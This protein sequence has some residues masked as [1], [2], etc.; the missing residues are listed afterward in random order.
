MKIVNLSSYAFLKLD[1]LPAWKETLLTLCHAHHVKGTI[2]LA[3]EGINLALAGEASDIQAFEAAFKAMPEFAH[4]EFKV[5]YSQTIPFR[6]MLVK[7]KQAVIPMRDADTH[8]GE[9]RAPAMLP[10][11][12]KAR[13][14]AG[15]DIVLLD[16]RNT[17]EIEF[18]KF[19]HAVELDL[20]H[21]DDFNKAVEALKATHQDKTIVSY[22][23]GGVRCEK[24]A[25]SML[26]AGFKDVYQ[27][28]G[29]ILKYFELCGGDHW[30]GSCFVFDEREALTPDL[31]SIHES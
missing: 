18:G 15:E 7:L 9:A 27:L 11:A 23:T 31:K 25:I 29:G 24:A 16:T 14:D 19:K 22:C 4:I 20:K 8:P 17:Y 1:D 3:P 10:E 12:L 5:S 2:L 6:K 13:L 21:F 26:D 28:E 30:E